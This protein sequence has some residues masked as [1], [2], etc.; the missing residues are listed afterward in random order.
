MPEISKLDNERAVKHHPL[1]LSSKY[2]RERTH[3][4]IR[5]HTLNV[6][7]IKH[8]ERKVQQQKTGE[9]ATAKTHEYEARKNGRH[10]PGASQEQ[11]QNSINDRT[12]NPI[13]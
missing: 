8:R 2:I 3:A 10:Q 12:R 9:R 5:I 4:R 1:P 11:P 7:G 6:P 13:G